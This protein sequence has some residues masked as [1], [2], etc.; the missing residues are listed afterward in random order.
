MAFSRGLT[1]TDLNDFI[2][3][4][5]ACIKPVEEVKPQQ[6]VENAASTQIGI[7]SAGVY[8]E[9]S[10]QDPGRKKL[11]QAQIS[12][13]DCLACSGCIT[14]AES[15]LISMQSH[16]EVLKTV[17]SNPAPSHPDHKTF[18]LSIAPQSLASLAASISPSATTQ[19][20]LRRVEAFAHKILG[21]SYTY[22]TT[23]ARHIALL[24]H[25]REF[26]ERGASSTSSTLSDDKPGGTRLPMIASACPGW[27]CYVEKAHPEMIP[28]L[29]RTKSPQQ[30]M[31]TLVKAWLARRWGKSANS[32]YHVTVMPCYDKKLEASRQDF[33]SD[34]LSTRDVDC[35][36]TTAELEILMRDKGWD[37]SVPV[38]GEDENRLPSAEN[39]VL[40]E[41]VQH[42]GSS[43]GS[44]LQS[45]ID[46]VSLGAKSPSVSTKTIRTTDYEEYTVTDEA[47][48]KILFRGA[49][50]YGFRN[51]QNI[52]RKVGRDAG[53]SVS[54]GAA[55]RVAMRGRRAVSA[56]ARKGLQTEEPRSYDYVEVMACPAG[57]VNGGGQLRGG[58][59]PQ[60]TDSLDGVPESAATRDAR[61]GDKQLVKDVE[62]IY[63]G[64][65]WT[66]PPSP[67]GKQRAPILV[68]A[69]KL[70]VEVLGDLCQSGSTFSRWSDS[71]DAEAES[72]RCALFR[73]NFRA[74]ESE[75]VGLAVQW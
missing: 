19:Q 30:V 32:I 8:Y 42:P 5:Q 55:G 24:E 47:D 7:D 10:R 36:L 21:F 22:D 45:L 53:V 63:W 9:E 50:C 71:M 31:G 38:P 46:S 68:T 2:T 62:A 48:G 44:Y 17:E 73:T 41:L 11:Q 72:L 51:L 35:V 1:L 67:T 23:F 37:I 26:F 69:D 57:C 16:E 59:R 20:V 29:S 25:T 65:V 27:V 64:G 14:S 18:V 40:P 33:Y 6:E 52:V 13:N 66:P 74:V 49:K 56:V 60:A 3:P 12:L 70:A 34:L 75:V 28:F 39:G 4:S 15:V 58:A 61:W 43:S 54:R